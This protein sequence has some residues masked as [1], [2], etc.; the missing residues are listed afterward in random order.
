M[1]VGTTG[2]REVQRTLMQLLGELDGFTPRGQVSIMGASNRPDI[3]DEALLRTLADDYEL[4]SRWDWDLAPELTPEG[5]RDYLRRLS[6]CAPSLDGVVNA[7][8]RYGCDETDE[9]CHELLEAHLDDGE[10][11]DDLNDGLFI[12]PCKVKEEQTAGAPLVCHPSET[13]PLT[14]KAADNKFVAGRLNQAIG[15]VVQA[16]ASRTQNGFVAGR[17]LLQ[18]AVDLDFQGRRLAMEYA[19]RPDCCSNSS[20]AN[21]TLD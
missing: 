10:T 18:N 13:R 19:V 3:L 2:D 5:S 4:H 17:Q 8:W 14:L 6:N 20:L 9:Y 21:M 12:F 1:D 16:H 11:P 7:A 15:P